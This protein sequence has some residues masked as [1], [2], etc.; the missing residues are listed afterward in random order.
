MG[1]RSVPVVKGAI[2]VAGPMAVTLADAFVDDPVFSWVLHDDPRRR[3]VLERFFALSLRRIWLPQRECYTTPDEAGVAVWQLPDQWK[4]GIG[5]QLRLGPALTSIFGR[6]LPRALRALTTLE[7][8]H[9]RDR[10]YYLAYIGVR[11]T[12]Q[13]HGIGS[14]LLTPMLAR[15]DA[16]RMPAYLEASTER[17][18]SLYERHGFTVVDEIR[19]GRGAPPMW[20]MRRTP[21]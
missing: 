3:R 15:C 13:G 17:N 9:P 5:T 10:H 14:A 8:H 11:S 18:R 7:S 2:G 19:L 20:P 1:G 21:R 6:H 16:E 12:D 4:L